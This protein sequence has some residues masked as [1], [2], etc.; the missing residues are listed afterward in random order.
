MQSVVV[1]YGAN[2]QS[3]GIAAITFRGGNSAA[4]AADKLD[5]T[6]VDG[7][8]MKVLLLDGQ[9]IRA[10]RLTDDV[11]DRGHHI[12]QTGTGS[13]DSRRSHE[14]RI[15]ELDCPLITKSAPSQPKTAVGKAKPKV[16]TTAK[17]A[18]GVKAARGGAA[19]RGGRGGRNGRGKPKTADELDAEMTDYFVPKETVANGATTNGAVAANTDAS[20]DDQIM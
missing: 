6:K 18:V 15:H 2:G 20:M 9:D 12:C 10:M 1:T 8:P 19:K 7:R 4:V 5:G 14:V 11:T 17:P 3:R 13:Q 16:A